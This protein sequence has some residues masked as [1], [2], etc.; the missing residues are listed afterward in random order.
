MIWVKLALPL[1]RFKRSQTL[2]SRPTFFRVALNLKIGGNWW[3]VKLRSIQRISRRQKLI[4]WVKSSS[5][6]NIKSIVT[7]FLCKS[8]AIE[9]LRLAKP[10]INIS[11]QKKGKS[12][13]SL[14]TKI[15]EKVKT[16]LNHQLDWVF[17]WG[18][19]T[20]ITF[21]L[22]PSLS[23][24]KELSQTETSALEVNLDL[25]PIHIVV[26]ITQGRRSHA[27]HHFSR[28]MSLG[29]VSKHNFENIFFTKQSI[30]EE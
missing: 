14:E 25:T 12:F 11:E 16:V 8:E 13:G 5:K 7:C 3:R 26:E 24:V 2:I 6:S 10:S 29:I 22:L 17:F 9:F 19:F 15:S 20:C 30:K 1:G 21:I 28:L 4:K 27:H 18:N 23:L